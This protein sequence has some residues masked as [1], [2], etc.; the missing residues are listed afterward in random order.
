LV[1]IFVAGVEAYE[2][3]QGLGNG[4]FASNG[5]FSHR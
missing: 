2:V 3:W 1:D 5:R 4:R